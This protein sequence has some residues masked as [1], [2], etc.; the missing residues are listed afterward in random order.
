RS[1]HLLSHDIL[2][3]LFRA[4]MSLSRWTLDRIDKLLY[5]VDEWLRFRT[6]ENQ[7]MF[8]LKLVVGLLWFLITY[9]IRFAVTLL[10]EPQVNPIK[11]FPVVTVSHKLMLPLVLSSNPAE[12]PSTF[13]ALLMRV[14]SLDA[15]WANFVAFWTVAGIPGIFGFLAW[16]L[17]ENWRLYRANQSP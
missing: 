11:H 12:R 7:A 6:G 5:T 15:G 14:T 13:G 1:W 16:E 9:V 17:K 10:F 3:G 8:V 4:I 2:P